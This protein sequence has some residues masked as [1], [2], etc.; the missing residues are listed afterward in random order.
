MQLRSW[1]RN[2]IGSPSKFASTS[3]YGCFARRT[4]LSAYRDDELD[5]EEREDVERQL[6]ASEQLRDQYDS[7]EKVDQQLRRW[8]RDADPEEIAGVLQDD[9]SEEHREG[10]DGA[11][12]AEPGDRRNDMSDSTRRGRL[13]VVAAAMIAGL[14]GAVVLFQA[15]PLADEEPGWNEWVG[16]MVAD[17]RKYQAGDEEMGLRT[18]DV[19]EVERWF[20]REYDLRIDNPEWSPGSLVGAN[21]C[22]LLDR[23]VAA[24]YLDTGDRFISVYAVDRDMIGTAPDSPDEFP[25]ACEQ[26]EDVEVCRWRDADWQMVAIADLQE[27]PLE[28]DLLAAVQSRHEAR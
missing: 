12:P 14:I 8:A 28:R 21:R 4:P 22:T 24:S 9:E 3:H 19:D 5:A 26:T 1:C 18:P 10:S 6:A 25:G 11:S 20:D 7:I 2:N 15:D 23:P 16:E 13:A 27:S 17:H